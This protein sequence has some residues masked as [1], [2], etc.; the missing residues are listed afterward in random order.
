HTSFFSEEGT[1]RYGGDG[2]AY[3][4]FEVVVMA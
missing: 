3:Y 2:R 4:Q 1:R